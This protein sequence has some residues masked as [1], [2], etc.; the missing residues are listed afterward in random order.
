M[1]TRTA[2][3]A[4]VVAI[5]AIVERFDHWQFRRKDAFRKCLP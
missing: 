2:Q 3:A 1:E 4:A 5:V